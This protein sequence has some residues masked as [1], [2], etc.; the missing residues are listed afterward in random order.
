M[1]FKQDAFLRLICDGD[2]NG[3]FEQGR[4]YRFVLRV[5]LDV[6][7]RSQYLDIN[8]AR[9]DDKRMHGIMGYIEEPFPHQRHLPVVDPET[10]VVVA[11]L[12]AGIDPYDGAVRQGDLG[13]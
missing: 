2:F 6:K 7:G 10:P 13:L 8:L 12:A 1:W 5:G 3:T 4:F 11:Q 9:L